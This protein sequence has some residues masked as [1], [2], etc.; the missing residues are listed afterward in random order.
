M[1]RYVEVDVN[2]EINDL[3]YC[4][5]IKVA[6][7]SNL[8]LYAIVIQSQECKNYPQKEHNKL[9][10]GFQDSQKVISAVQPKF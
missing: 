3:R 1:D 4:N 10:L 7:W 5:N 8:N 6:S 9:N 2:L